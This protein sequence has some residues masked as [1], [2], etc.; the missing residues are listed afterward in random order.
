VQFQQVNHITFQCITANTIVYNNLCMGHFV[1]NI[2]STVFN[3]AVDAVIH[4]FKDLTFLFEEI[5][6]TTLEQ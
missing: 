4:K 3:F 6:G 1:S 5:L 2:Y